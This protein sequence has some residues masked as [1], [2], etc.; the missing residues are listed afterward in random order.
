MLDERLVDNEAGL[1]KLLAPPFDG[2][3]PNPG[4]IQGYLPGVRENGGQY[5]H[6]AIWAVMAFARNG[7]V[8]RA[9]Q[10]WSLINPVNHGRTPEDMERYKV[11]PYVMTADIYSVDPHIGRGGWSWYTGSAGWAYRLV[12]ETLLG[13]QR[14]GNGLTVRP[15]LPDAW[16][17]VSL[18]YRHGESHYH[19]NAARSDGEYE[20]TLNGVLHAGNTIPLIDDGQRHAVEIG[21]GS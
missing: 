17:S 7:N 14:H 11:E 1:I 12:L 8:E 4:Y 15:L 18:V 5:T 6:G 13:V 9:W 21:L 3:G 19:I 2:N 20:I 10:L 16:L